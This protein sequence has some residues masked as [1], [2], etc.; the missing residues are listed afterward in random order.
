MNV[1]PIPRQL[2]LTFLP[3]SESLK[4]WE[5]VLLNLQV[6]GRSLELHVSLC[7][8]AVL[9]L[10]KFDRLLAGAFVLRTVQCCYIITFGKNRSQASFFFLVCPP[11][12][13]V[14]YNIRGGK[15]CEGISPPRTFPPRLSFASH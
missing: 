4:A 9:V 13:M 6:K 8:L 11:F 10:V 12:L 14:T 3:K 5:N 1:L 2:T 15:V 7:L